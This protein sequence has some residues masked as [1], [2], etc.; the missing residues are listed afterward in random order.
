VDGAVASL[1]IPPPGTTFAPKTTAIAC[2]TTDAHGN[3]AHTR[4]D[5]TVTYAAP[6]DDNF[7]LSP[8]DPHGHAVFRRGTIVP[9]RFT[10]RGPSARIADLGATIGIARVSDGVVG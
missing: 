8:L 9:V 3:A 5:I 4:F 7:F 10:L 1:C 2:T 6:T